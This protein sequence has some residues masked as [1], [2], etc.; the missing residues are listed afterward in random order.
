[1]VLSKTIAKFTSVYVADEDRIQVSCEAAD[2]SVFRM[3]LTR[4]FTDKALIALFGFAEQISPA[5]PMPP[6][7]QELWRSNLQQSAQSQL[8]SAPP[9]APASPAVEFLLT[10]LVLTPQESSL[11]LL[12]QALQGETFGLVLSPSQLLQWVKILHECYQKAGWTF[13]GWPDWFLDANS[14]SIRTRSALAH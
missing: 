10:K 8:G 13:A 1:M 4:R 2:A 5:T 9:V 11:H 12:F 3:W 14:P 7:V 6:M